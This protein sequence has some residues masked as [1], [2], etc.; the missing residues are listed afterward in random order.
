[1]VVSKLP[2]HFK[3]LKVNEASN[4]LKIIA[5]AGLIQVIQFQNAPGSLLTAQ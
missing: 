3:C 5:L 1:M 4:T 2:E